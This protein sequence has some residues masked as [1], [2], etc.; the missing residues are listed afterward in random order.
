MKKPFQPQT[1]K[2]YEQRNKKAHGET[3]VKLNT[4]S[5]EN[6]SRD[7]RQTSNE[8]LPNTRRSMHGFTHRGRNLSF[9]I[10]LLTERTPSYV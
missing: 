4:V 3:A 8:N 2:F 5:F 10:Y 6:D 7:S 9:G 1:L